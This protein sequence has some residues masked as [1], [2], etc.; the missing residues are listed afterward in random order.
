MPKEL[1]LDSQESNDLRRLDPQFQIKIILEVFDLPK[2]KEKNEKRKQEFIGLMRSYN[3]AYIK[4][5][6]DLSSGKKRDQYE[7]GRAELHNKIMEI[8]TN[9]SLSLGLSKEQREVISYLSENRDEVT[10]MIS[11]YFSGISSTTINTPSEY[12]KIKDQLDALS[13]KTGPEEE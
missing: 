9:M 4:S 5:R 1:L 2:D 12:A 11:S 6:N 3:L 7:A 10:K 13:G 8:L